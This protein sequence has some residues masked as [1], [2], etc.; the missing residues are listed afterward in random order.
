MADR[1]CRVVDPDGDVLLVLNNPCA[2]FAIWTESDY[3]NIQEINGCEPLLED[4]LSIRSPMSPLPV[5]DATMVPI[6]E[7][8]AVEDSPQDENPGVS[9]SPQPVD[10]EITLL[11][12]VTPEP[13]LTEPFIDEPAANEFMINEFVLSSKHLILASGYFRAKLS[14][15]WKEAS[16]RGVDGRYHVEA[17]DW[18]DQALLLVMRVL[19]GKNSKIPRRISLEL[20]AKIA[21]LVDY[22]DCF[23]ATEIISSIWI[24]AL[25][26]EIPSELNRELVL[27]LLISKVFH[28]SEIILQVTKTAIGRSLGLMPALGL[29]IPSETLDKKQ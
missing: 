17:S 11:E 22:Y 3:S 20:L 5:E 27:W 12:P 2:P 9:F 13:A 8:P 16:T 29:P 28:Q 26:N 23:E 1:I 7:E 25:R 24:D 4:I 19:H 10:A 18:D 21:V 15:P 14:G 6:S